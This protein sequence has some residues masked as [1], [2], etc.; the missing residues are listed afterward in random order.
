MVFIPQTPTR[1]EGTEQA[2]ERSSAIQQFRFRLTFSNNRQVEL[3]AR[4]LLRR[5]VNFNAA[6]RLINEVPYHR[7]SKPRSA[8]FWL[9]RKERFEYLF[10]DVGGN[11]A[12]G[13]SDDQ[14]NILLAIVACGRARFPGLDSDE[15]S[16]GHGVS[17]IYY[18]VYECTFEQVRIT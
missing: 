9:R 18:K 6:A 2:L 14:G 4:A 11:A 13:I 7:K 10:Q 8:T 16:L 5:A 3:D 12:S 1:P 17:A 15:T